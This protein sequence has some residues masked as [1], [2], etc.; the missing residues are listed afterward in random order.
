MKVVEGLIY[1]YILKENYAFG[2]KTTYSDFLSEQVEKATDPI[3]SCYEDKG[4]AKLNGN[5]HSTNL[6]RNSQ[7]P[8]QTLIRKTQTVGDPNSRHR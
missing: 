5:S 6:L 4:N 2:M 1:R 8:T 3:N 7:E